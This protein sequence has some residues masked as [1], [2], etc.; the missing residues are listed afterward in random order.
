MMKKLLSLSR[1][2]AAAAA[3]SVPSPAHADPIELEAALR[4]GGATNPGWIGNPFAFGF[5]G[6]AGAS[7]YGFYAGL[8]AT[9]YLGAGGGVDGFHSLLIGLEA[10]YTLK[11][12]RVRLR[13]Q[14]GFGEGTFSQVVADGAFNPTTTDMVGNVYVEP[15]LVA[16]VTIGPI[17]VGADAGAILLPGFTL[18]SPENA[19]GMPEYPAVAK[20]YGSFSAHGQVGV[21]F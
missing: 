18:A 10:G 11:L 21:L 14:V 16:L 8:S 9:Y 1:A 13:P 6:R 20:T 17:F 12:G 3:L 15:A 5:G 7:F 19:D 2:C 4:A